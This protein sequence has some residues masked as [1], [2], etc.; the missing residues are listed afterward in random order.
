MPIL[1]RL[2]TLSAIGLLIVGIS[3]SRQSSAKDTLRQRLVQDAYSEHLARVQDVLPKHSGLPPLLDVSKSNTAEGSGERAW[4]D[5]FKGV[6]GFGTEIADRGV[7][8]PS[9]ATSI[10][11]ATTE[12]GTRIYALPAQSCGAV[13]TAEPVASEARI[14]QNRLF[15]YSR[16]SLQ[17]SRVL[18]ANRKLGI[19][20]GQRIVATQFGGSVRFPSGHME[21][22]LL[23]KDGFLELRKQYL[24]FIWKP[25]ESI[26]A[27][28]IAQPYQIQGGLVFPVSTI[29]D[30]SAY[31]RMPIKD[32]E[33]KVRT[34]IAKNVD[35]N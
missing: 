8:S 31:D 23:A 7:E 32:F 28:M 19:R 14:A 33:A 18:K 34:A 35:S 4:E 13:V 6:M 3:L 17:V 30:V 25:A 12:G 10:S 22:F 20:Q 15:V 9:R 1:A 29:A 5:R 16:F 21:T 24:L 26:Q 27:F 2:T 11:L